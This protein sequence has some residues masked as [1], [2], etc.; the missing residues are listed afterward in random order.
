MKYQARVL[1]ISDQTDRRKNYILYVDLINFLPK[2]DIHWCYGEML[3]I[4]TA[5]LNSKLNEER[6]GLVN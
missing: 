4:S 1:N 6:S 3:Y 2:N 5:Q